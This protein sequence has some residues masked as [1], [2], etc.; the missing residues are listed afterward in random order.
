MV[1]KNITTGESD[2]SAN[3][4]AKWQLLNRAYLNKEIAPGV[5][6]PL[7][8]CKSILD[9]LTDITFLKDIGVVKDVKFDIAT[10]A[11]LDQAVGTVKVGVRNLALT[12]D[13]ALVNPVINEPVNP[14]YP[15]IKVYATKAEI[16]FLTQVLAKLND[17]YAADG[18]YKFTATGQASEFV[19]ADAAAF[20]ASYTL[21]SGAVLSKGA[22]YWQIKVGAN[23]YTGEA[24]VADG[25]DPAGDYIKTIGTIAASGDGD[26]NWSF[27]AGEGVLKA[28]VEDAAATDDGYELAEG[29]ILKKV[30]DDYVII[31]G[32]ITYTQ[33]DTPTAVDGTYSYKIGTISTCAI[34]NADNQVAAS[35]TAAEAATGTLL[36]VPAAVEAPV[37]AKAAAVE[38]KAEAPVAKT[39]TKRK[40]KGAEMSLADLDAQNAGK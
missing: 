23:T 5:A 4:T 25:G 36:S 15:V 12:L 7:A 40:A 34:Q 26:I 18:A 30:G 20:A 32:G 39:V 1:I 35:K 2:S 21:A 3:G 24:T 38:V 10:K 29:V 14:N 17:L 6:T 16:A 8:S 28:T 37:V 19:C 11:P 9:V 13:G 22:T 27:N 33:A 31:S